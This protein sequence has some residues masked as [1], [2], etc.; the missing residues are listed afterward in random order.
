[1]RAHQKT[2]T[3]ARLHIRAFL[4]STDPLQLI[5]CVRRQIEL[6]NNLNP[7]NILKTRNTS[8]EQIQNRMHPQT[9]QPHESLPIPVTATIATQRPRLSNGEWCHHDP[10]E[11]TAQ[12]RTERLAIQETNR[13][14][15]ATSIQTGK[16]DTHTPTLSFFL[17]TRPT[18]L[19]HP[20]SLLSSRSHN[21]THT[22]HK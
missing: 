10:T 1:M 19:F 13:Q 20:C 7:Q 15:Y 21:H 18:S 4:L 2:I 17:S 9:T 5:Q 6:I 8:A 3:Q 14:C 22:H 16:N 11:M 12:N